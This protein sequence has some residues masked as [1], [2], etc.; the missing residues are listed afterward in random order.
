MENLENQ[1]LEPLQESTPIPETPQEPVSEQVPVEECCDNSPEVVSQS[2]ACEE[3]PLLD[4]PAQ[5]DS[6]R[7]KSSGKALKVAK[8][9]L[10]ALLVLALVTAG[11]GVTAYGLSRYYNEQNSLLL[12]Y[13]NTQIEYLQDQIDDTSYTG[14][15][16]SISGTPNTSTDG[17]T[18]AQVYAK[19]VDSV[20]SIVST[21]SAGSSSGSGFIISPDGYIMTNFHVVDGAE[22]VTVTLHDG[23]TLTAQVKG[24]DDRNDIALLK[25]DA[26]DLPA[27]KLGSSNDLIVGDQVVAI[28]NPLGTLS[29]TL[30]VGYIGGKERFISTDGSM[31]NMLQTDAAINS[32]N[33]GG[34]LFNMKGEVV[35]ITT[36]KI[37]GLSSNGSTMEGLGFAIPMDDIA[38]KI[39]QLITNGYVS[40]PYMGVTVTNLVSGFGA[41]VQGVDAGS[42]AAIAGIRAGDVIMAMDAYKVTSVETLDK[43]MRNFTV[44]QEISV[45]VLRNQQ[46]VNL[47]LTLAERPHN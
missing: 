24:Y 3:T 13:F 43:A 9:I 31:M 26:T 20:V 19:C 27:A 21:T 18:P 33:S 28:G 29:S 32:G 34:P 44:G 23:T 6:P 4:A 38:D 1:N 39:Q 46:I 45:T 15:G 42:A 2:S 25:V 37:S 8:Y 7:A 14:N 10:C 36:A 40:S 11:C 22:W 30:T 47:K 12:N 16:N 41:Y 35:G 17:L 5:E